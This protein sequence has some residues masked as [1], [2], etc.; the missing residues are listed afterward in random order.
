MPKCHRRKSREW[1]K[2]FLMASDSFRKQAPGLN[3]NSYVSPELDRVPKK[4]LKNA[5]TCPICNNSFLEGRSSK[6]SRVKAVYINQLI[7]SSILDD[8]PLVVRLPCHKDHKFDL[9][10]IAPWLRLHATCPLDR[11]VLSKKK[12]PPPPPEEEDGEYDDYYA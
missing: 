11:K 7:F 10:C 1:G 4:S 3:A 9:E 2:T 6:D 8:Y 5:D 12:P